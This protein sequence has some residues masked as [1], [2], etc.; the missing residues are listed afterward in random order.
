MKV[1]YLSPGK[2]EGAALTL[3][4]E[5][6]RKFPSATLLPVPVDDIVDCHLELDFG[7]ANLIG[8]LGVPDVL[9]ALW[10][11]ERK[12]QIDQSLDPT[13]FPAQEGRYHFTVAHECGHWILH[14]RYFLDKAAQPSLFGGEAEPSIVCRS[15][16][17]K[18]PVEWQADTFASYLL[19][20]KE[21]V[22]AV[23]QEKHGSLEPYYAAEE[24]A[25]LTARWSV[26]DGSIP[27]VRVA[28][29]MAQIFK[30]SG[31]AMQIR[32]N[33]LGLIQTSNEQSILV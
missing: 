7:F 33:S 28:K 8:E 2:I 3:L 26:A 4:A 21:Q 20:P 6:Q 14:R 32:L 12:V 31:Q 25:G 11:N 29:E 9:G 30:V 1:D 5:Y 10:M 22:F 15:S 19:M 27:T 18:K 24:I 16:Q 23:W 13:N 17:K